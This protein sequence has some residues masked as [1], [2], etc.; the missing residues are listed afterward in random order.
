MILG[1]GPG[2]MVA[3]LTAAQRGHRVTLI[4][5]R[6]ELGGRLPEA[7]ANDYKKEIMAYCTWLKRQIEKSTVQV[8]YNVQAD[9]AYVQGKQPDAV[10]VA[11]GALPIIPK[12]PGYEKALLAEDI[13]RDRVQTGQR[14][15]VVGGGLVGCETADKLAG[16]GKQVTIVEMRP[17]LLMDTSVVYRHAALK[18]MGESKAA[19]MTGVALSAIDDTG[20]VV[21]GEQQIPC[22]DV[23]WAVGFKTENTLYR[24]LY[25]TMDEVYLVGDCKGARKIFNAVQEAY[26]IAAEL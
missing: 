15:V 6:N 20:A 21:S 1:G 24:A 9:E 26:R 22:D 7:G 10:I 17:E 3:A 25:E 23:V 2:G 18:K 14:V 8:E 11:T 4:E 12:V 16:Q 19:V 13:L 5:G